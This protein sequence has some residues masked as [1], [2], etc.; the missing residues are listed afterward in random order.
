[1]MMTVQ[2][3]LDQVVSLLLIYHS[4]HLFVLDNNQNYLLILDR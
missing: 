4:I 3:Q 1:M 2:S